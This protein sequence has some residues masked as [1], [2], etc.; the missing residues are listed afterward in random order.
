MAC[1]C[2]KPSTSSSTSYV[3]KAPDGS[4]KTYRTEMEAKAAA[5]RVGG[6]LTKK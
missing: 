5:S 2:S 1:S 6:T 4:T 3:V